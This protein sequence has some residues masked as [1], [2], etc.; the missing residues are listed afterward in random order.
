MYHGGRI[1][2]NTKNVHQDVFISILVYLA[3]G[4]LFIVSLRIKGDSG[5]FPRL[6]MGGLA[7]LNT[8]LLFRGIKKTKDAKD[9]GYDIENTITLQDIKWP[10]IVLA[11]T[12]VYVVIFNYTNFFVAS[13][14]FLIGLMKMYKMKSWKTILLVTLAFNV[15]IYL[16]FVLALKVPLI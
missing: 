9:N 6:V 8:I 13:T 7:F 3:L 10:L 5:L 16:G 1:R 2:L 4:F 15:F 11:V 12:V 14:I